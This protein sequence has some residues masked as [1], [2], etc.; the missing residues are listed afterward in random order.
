MTFKKNDQEK[1]KLSKI[2][3]FYDALLGVLK[4]VD[5]GAKKYGDG[6]WLTASQDDINRYY[7][8]GQRHL[9]AHLRG[10]LID[11]DSGNPH[12]YHAITTLLMATQLE[13]KFI[14]ENTN[15]N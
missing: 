14:K 11:D 13:E 12:I 1:P 3:R 6:N 7:E 5:F 9:A 10:E 2:W 15:E 4:I 8:A